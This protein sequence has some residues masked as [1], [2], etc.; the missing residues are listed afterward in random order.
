[1]TLQ[2]TRGT[3]WSFES[4][5]F[6]EYPDGPALLPL[7]PS[8]Y[9]Q[10]VITDPN[11]VI[12]QQGVARS[13]TN[14]VYTSYFHVPSD[15]TVS[16]PTTQW[17]IEW[18]LVTANGRQIEASLTFDVVDNVEVGEEERAY[19]Y[20][21]RMGKGERL[22]FRTMELPDE[23][24]LEVHDMS[25][26]IIFSADRTANAGINAMDGEI[27]EV[28][29]G[30]QYTYY[31]DVPSTSF[32][33]PTEYHALW[34]WRMTT[35]SPL[36]TMM[37]VVRIVPQPIWRWFTPLRMMIDKLQKK[38]GRP[39]AYTDADIYEYLLRGV[40]I[41]NA[42]APG[43]SWTLLNFPHYC[44]A[45]SLLLAGAA[46]WALRAQ[47]I[48]EGELAFCFAKGTLVSTPQG[49]VPIEKLIGGLPPGLYHRKLELIT[50]EGV[51]ITDKVYVSE[52][53]ETKTVITKNGYEVTCTPNEPFLVLTKDLTLEWKKV[54]DLHPGD[55]VAISK[56]A[57]KDS[58]PNFVQESLSRVLNP[59]KNISQYHHLEQYLEHTQ[60]PLQELAP[61]FLE[62]LNTLL[63]YR[64]HYEE[65]ESIQ[66]AGIQSTYDVC[67]PTTSNF[68]SNSFIANGFVVHNSYGG[69]TL[70]LDL[71]H[72][73][74][75][76]EAASM[77]QQWLDDNARPS[78]L[79]VLRRG[80]NTTVG[81]RPY[82]INMASVSRPMRG[83]ANFGQ[84]AYTLLQLL[85]V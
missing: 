21:T 44:G 81:L 45:D 25:D 15:A 14:K 74:T 80:G 42:K 32:V 55:S 82:G 9:P 1:M 22:I 76:S 33:A 68:L 64:F 39:H 58:L 63:K 41:V 70:S 75:Y 4:P 38:Q 62:K 30:S 47:Y 18:V 10:F 73:G 69:Q 12:V 13:L 66:D 71:D 46:L 2:L 6:E 28:V 27:Q 50:P 36:E 3:G 11:G 57:Q 37:Q 34:D 49:L 43:T 26:N 84:G 56:E 51:Q 77:W 52:P 20:I 17:T 65:I 67:L 48:M 16:T 72:T 79:C 29:D 7:D 59:R 19:T 31:I 61:T 83:A 23:L 24:T 60:E 78:K 40:D 8:S 53:K 54:E 85:E 35:V 5:P